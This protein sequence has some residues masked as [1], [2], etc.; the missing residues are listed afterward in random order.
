MKPSKLAC[1][2]CPWFSEAR[3][4]CILDEYDPEIDIPKE[5]P[6]FNEVRR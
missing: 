2:F 5:C 6:R 4:D 1:F 3:L